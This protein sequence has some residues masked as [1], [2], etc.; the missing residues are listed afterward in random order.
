MGNHLARRSAICPQQSRIECLLSYKYITLPLLTAVIMF[1]P[2]E[3][4]YQK[5]AQSKDKVT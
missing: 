1:H 4:R 2:I 3:N 5:D